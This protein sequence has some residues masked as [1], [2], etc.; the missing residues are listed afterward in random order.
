ME[1][2]ERARPTSKAVGGTCDHGYRVAVAMMTVMKMMMWS[3]K[4]EEFAVIDD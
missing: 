3:G 2:Q 4:W 1:T